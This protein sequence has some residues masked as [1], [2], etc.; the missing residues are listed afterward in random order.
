MLDFLFTWK[1]KEYIIPA[2]G[3]TWKVGKYILYLRG[4]Y[5]AVLL[6]GVI[7]SIVHF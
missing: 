1:L 3:T 4:K 6:E 7:S 2:S 5:C